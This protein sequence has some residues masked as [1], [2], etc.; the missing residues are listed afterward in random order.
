LRIHLL[1][2]AKFKSWDLVAGTVVWH[3]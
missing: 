3:L 2:K 1:M